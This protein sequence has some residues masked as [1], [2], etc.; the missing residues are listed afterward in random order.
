MSVSL[1]ESAANQIKKQLEK[2]GKGIG[3]KLGIKKSGC[4][5]YAYALDYADELAENEAVFEHFGVKIIVQ[6][7]DLPVVDG[8]EVD[9]RR[10]GINAA[11]QFNNP[12]VKATCGCGESF[13]V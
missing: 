3:L 10:E 2:R 8:I 1:T 11:F 9:Y 5:G 13:S 7:A 4:S 12:N 6:E